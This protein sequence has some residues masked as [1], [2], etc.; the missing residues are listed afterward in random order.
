MSDFLKERIL[1][2]WEDVKNPQTELEA[3]L[4]L[5]EYFKSPSAEPLIKYDVEV[6]EIYRV[7]NLYLTAWRLYREGVIGSSQAKELEEKDPEAEG[8]ITSL[9]QIAEE[10][11]TESFRILQEIGLAGGALYRSIVSALSNLPTQEV[12]R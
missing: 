3:F 5:R 4:T 12:R 6:R 9:Y 1:T 8:E 11:F 10:K 2:N 7:T